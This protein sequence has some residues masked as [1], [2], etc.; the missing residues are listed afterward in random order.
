M[1]KPAAVSILAGV[2]IA[3]QAMP[4][5][6]QTKAPTAQKTAQTQSFPMPTEAVHGCLVAAARKHGLDYALVRSIAEQESRFNPLAVRA[7]YAA[8]NKDGSVDY[9]LMQINSSWLPTLARYGITQSAL[10]DP[11]V[12]ADVGGWILADLFRRHGITWDAVGAYNAKS[13]AKRYIYAVGVYTRLQRFVQ[14]GAQ[15]HA[16]TAASQLPTDTARAPVQLA[17]GGADLPLMGV[18]ERQHVAEGSSSPVETW[19]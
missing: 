3:M 9:G 1:V 17:Q 16:P 11:C 13:P 10:F 18:W 2:A 5:H 14:L 8:G 7:P 4:T 6:A 15:G 19:P 12:N